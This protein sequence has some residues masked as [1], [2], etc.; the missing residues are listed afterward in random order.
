[1]EWRDSPQCPPP[2]TGEYGMSFRIIGAIALLSCAAGAVA[3]DK[4]DLDPG[5]KLP[6]AESH[7]TATLSPT[8][9]RRLFALDTA[10]PAAEAGKTLVIDGGAGK[11][12]GMFSQGYWSNFAIAPD[13]SAVYGADTYF[14]KHTRGKRQDF[15]V[16]RD[17][18]TLEVLKD[19]PLP[20]GRLLIVSKKYNF[21]VTPDGRY[22]LSFNLAPRTAVS[23]VD[24]KLGEYVGD[25]DIPGCGLIFPQAPNRFTTLCADGSVATVTFDEKLKATTER[26]KKVFDAEKDPVFEHS[27]WDKHDRM[28]YLV[29][30]SG[31]VIPLDLSG[32]AAAKLASWSLTN[33]EEKAAGWKPGGWQ[34]THF[35]VP[36]KRLYVLMHRGHEWT[37]KDSGTEVWVFDVQ[38][39]KRVQK[40]KL[41]KPTQSIAVSQ[42]DAPLLYGVVE[43]APEIIT[44]NVSDGSVRSTLDNMGFTPQ[45]LT[46]PGE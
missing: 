14:E 30:Y 10:F 40:I 20:N 2:F 8:H 35:H 36:Q 25:I 37:H 17:A 29:S 46:V 16:V 9:P 38:A 32:A 5:A 7:V 23:V 24:L 3:Q 26:V 1:M 31:T 33:P 22:G 28:L 41:K 43:G 44:Y 13:G 39:Q 11:L 42:D 27:G 15:V 21:G 18:R 4:D 19:I 34:V 6:V 45:L 12:E